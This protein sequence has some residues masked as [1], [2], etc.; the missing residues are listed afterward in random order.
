MIAGT[1]RPGPWRPG[2]GGIAACVAGV[3]MATVA[4]A[5]G[6][7]ALRAGESVVLTVRW[8]VEDGYYLDE[9]T[10][11]SLSF[12]APE[13]IAI[14]PGTVE[15]EGRVVGTA[16]QQARL[17]VAAGAKAGRREVRGNLVLFFCS[18][19]EQWCRRLTRDVGL[20]IEVVPDRAGPPGPV[21]IEVIVP[22]DD[23]R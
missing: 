10:P 23:E 3:L 16:E 18:A 5:A 1:Q 22:L 2:P 13:G 11:S 21:E 7:A 12:V 4:G 14:V 6:P 17:S 19:R 9:A 8:V 15:T 20:A